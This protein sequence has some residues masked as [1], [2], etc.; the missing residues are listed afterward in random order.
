MTEIISAGR[1]GD[2]CI[3]GSSMLSLHLLYPSSS[4][5]LSPC[6]VIGLLSIGLDL[7]QVTKREY[8]P[9]SAWKNWLWKSEG[10]LMMNGA[11]FVP[12]GNVAAALVLVPTLLH[13]R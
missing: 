9:E 8:A 13:C 12:S 10:D 7:D 6:D 3:F 11:C 2:R 4:I 5:F 1:P